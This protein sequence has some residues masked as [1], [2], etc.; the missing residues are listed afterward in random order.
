VSPRIKKESTGRYTFRILKKKGV[1]QGRNLSKKTE[2]ED[3]SL[4]EAT[5]F[6]WGHEK[7][8]GQHISRG[9]TLGKRIPRSLKRTG[10]PFG[11]VLSGK[12]RV[13]GIIP[14]VGDDWVP[15]AKKGNVPGGTR[16][17]FGGVWFR[18][19]DKGRRERGRGSLEH[20][21]SSP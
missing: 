18:K 10:E 12:K 20:R 21:E 4:T 15:G 6:G 7:S 16:D 3:I 19:K 2:M 13:R 5:V 8:G 17:R 11:L 14:S 1:Q 9:G